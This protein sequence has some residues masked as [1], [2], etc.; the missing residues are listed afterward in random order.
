MAAVCGFVARICKEGGKVTGEVGGGQDI[1]FSRPI[2][3]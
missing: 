3:T 2:I 1:S